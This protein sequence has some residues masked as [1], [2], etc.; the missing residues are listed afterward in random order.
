MKFGI[1]RKTAR[2]D[3]EKKNKYGAT[4]RYPYKSQHHKSNY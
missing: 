2:R 3:I 1:A 4:K